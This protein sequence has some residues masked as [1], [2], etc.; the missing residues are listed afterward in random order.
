MLDVVVD[1]RV[2]SPTF[3]KYEAVLL[4]SR[5]PRTLYISEGLGHAFMALEDNSTVCYMVSSGYAP[6]REFGVFPLDEEI[7][8]E[9][10]NEDG[11][12]NPISPVLSPKDLEAPTLAEA[13]EQG[14]LPKYDEVMAYRESLRA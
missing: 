13:L 10:P 4:D 14:L 11:S 8:I 12:G 7:G 5:S 6:G 3:G 1:I 9:W 2:G